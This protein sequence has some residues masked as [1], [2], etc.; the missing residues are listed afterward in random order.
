MDST[1]LMSL[2][3]NFGAH[4]YHPRPVVLDRGDGVFV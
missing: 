1:T 3:N 2:E 4:N